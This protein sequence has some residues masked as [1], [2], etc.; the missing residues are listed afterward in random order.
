MEHTVYHLYKQAQNI[1]P[2]SQRLQLPA[3]VAYYTCVTNLEQ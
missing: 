3:D 1:G 2:P